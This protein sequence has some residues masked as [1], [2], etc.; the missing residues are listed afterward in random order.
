MERSSPAVQRV[1]IPGTLLLILFCLSTGATGLAAASAGLRGELRTNL[2]FVETRGVERHTIAASAVPGDGIYRQLPDGTVVTCIPGEDVCYWYTQGDVESSLPMAQDLRMN[3]WTPIEGLSGRLHLRG[4]FGSDAFW[5]RAEE[6]VELVS[7]F[8]Q[9]ER[10]RLR[11]RAGRIGRLGSL[12]LYEFDGASV[13][14]RSSRK[15]AVELYGGRALARGTSQPLD[16]FLLEDADIFAPEEPG[17]LFGGEAEAFLP[18]RSRLA[19]TYQRELRQDRGALYE[20]RG[21]LETHL[22]LRPFTLDTEVD[23]DFATERFQDVRLRVDSPYFH[24]YRASG[25]LR[26]RRPYF[27]LWTIWE[28]FAPVGY[29]EVWSSLAWTEARGRAGLQASASY[30]EY[31]DTDVV[32]DGTPVRDDGWQ[33]DVLGRWDRGSWRYDGAYKVDLGF[34][35]AGTQVQL[36]ALRAFGAYE[37]GAQ[38]VAAQQAREFRN[39]QDWM[40]GGG[41]RGRW[42]QA[43]WSAEGSAGVYRLSYDHRADYADWSQKRAYL[44]LGYE[45]GSDPGLPTRNAGRQGEEV[46]R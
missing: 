37:L 38:A 41:L 30:R 3:G 1:R 15:T 10:D 5:P 7:G 32:I 17:V 21:A 12:G 44:A 29:R 8:A 22:V 20:E 24:G 4:R 16:G 35:A 9:W 6:E 2:S 13:L 39:G 18:N 40:F 11:L 31:D 14:L 26:Y 45:F 34:A 43:P 36:G 23:Y 28:A 27:S 25:A 46:S 33:V 42:E 19:L